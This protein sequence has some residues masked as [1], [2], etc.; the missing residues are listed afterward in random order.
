MLR[1]VLSCSL[2][3]V[4]GCAS[5]AD[6]DG[7]GFGRDVDCDDHDSAVFPGA[8]EYC[9]GVDDDCDGVVDEDGLD[10]ATWYADADGDGYGGAR[11]AI[12][13]CEFP[14]GYQPFSDDCDDGDA[15]VNPAAT[16]RCNGVDDDCDG[17]ID[18]DATDT[19]TWYADDDGD[20]W[21]APDSGV[22]ACEAPEGRVD[23]DLDCD[24][25]DDQARP[26][27][28]W[29]LDED[30]DGY[31]LTGAEQAGCPDDDGV[32]QG[33]DCA[34]LDPDRHPGAP[35][36]CDGIDQDC[37]GV[38]D[39]DGIDGSDWYL[40]ADGDGWG[41]SATVVSACTA[42]DDHVAAPGDCAPDDADQHP[43]ALE[44]CDD[45]VDQDCN[46][47]VDNTCA[48]PTDLDLLAAARIQG[49]ALSSL[50]VGREAAA[51]DLDLD[52]ALDLAA[53]APG[54][55]GDDAD[56][57]GRVY[58]YAGPLS[59]VLGIDDAVATIT[60]VDDG[61]AAGTQLLALDDADGAGTPGLLVAAPG[62]DDDDLI[63]YNVGALGL[64][65]GPQSGA[66]SANQP[67]AMLHGYQGGQTLGADG[68]GLADMDGDGVDDL[69]VGSPSLYEDQG[70][71]FLVHGPL[72]GT[73]TIEEA[74]LRI[75]G[76]GAGLRFGED[77]AGGGDHD[78]DGI[79]DLAVGAPPW[80]GAVYLWYG[81]LDPGMTSDEADLFMEGDEL[82]GRDGEQLRQADFDGDGLSDLLVAGPGR[83][84]DDGSTGGGRLA[85]LLGGSTGLDPAP[86]LS[87][88]GDRDGDALGRTGTGLLFTDLDGDGAA[89]LG[90]GMP[91]ND[92]AGSN[93]GA[94]GILYGPLAG[95]LPVGRADIWIEGPGTT[96]YLGSDLATAR[97]DGVVQALVIGAIQGESL[98]G[99]AALLPVD[100]LR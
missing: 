72:S 47:V 82:G 18:E 30:G 76:E 17:E 56:N 14:S 15:L 24:D 53:A 87:V 28:T 98:G 27:G 92:D 39:E 43:A 89:E 64:W 25:A 63:R 35:E 70:V 52:G 48:G 86:V 29:Y 37:D 26:D 49:P 55:D 3:L 51:L 44:V 1:F 38:V 9:N 2:L 57:L 6:K 31:G 5:D 69:L 81:P 22:Q 73:H 33:G 45:G 54:F 65:L 10:G 100:G 34:D 95:S 19:T 91:E 4:A 21:G 94:V 75:G 80:R 32:T 71:V 99:E 83:T 68:L 16:E 8:D 85:V 40:D 90:Y 23:N 36:L 59:G 97:I 7:D 78:G 67:D 96:A 93:A 79:A 62:W 66:L 20:G 46:G 58:L 77:V 13:A 61:D 11:Y 60:G 84:G 74:D 12:V 41:D 42:P 50:S 88:T